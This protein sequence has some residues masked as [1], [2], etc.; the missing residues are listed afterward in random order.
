MKFFTPPYETVARL[1]ARLRG[2][3]AEVTV[4]S[5]KGIAWFRCRKGENGP[6]SGRK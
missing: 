3:Y 6:E 1:E 4:G 2:M 5:I